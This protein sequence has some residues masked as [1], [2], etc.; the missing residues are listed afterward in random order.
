[1]T[2]KIDKYAKT[3][4]VKYK[5]GVDTVYSKDDYKKYLKPKAVNKPKKV[6]TIK[7]IE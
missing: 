1:M 4:Y 2:D 5:N 7:E 3:A 6:E